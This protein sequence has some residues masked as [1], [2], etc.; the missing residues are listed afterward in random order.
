ML[1][2][3]S[4]EVQSR[5]IPVF[6]MLLII[7]CLIVAGKTFVMDIEES[8]A[9]GADAHSAIQS[10]QSLGSLSD[11]EDASE[12]ERF[13]QTWGFSFPDLGRGDFF[14]LIGHMFVHGGILHLLSNLLLLWALGTAVEE[15]LGSIQFAMFYIACGIIAALGQGA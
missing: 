5:H 12:L 13:Y 2:V 3:G 8:L 1:V 7:A 14:S 15:A 6:C 10:S 4:S 11:G 9:D